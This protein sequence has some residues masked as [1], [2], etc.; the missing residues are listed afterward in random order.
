[1]E[2]SARDDQM[3]EVRSESASGHLP[4]NSVVVRG[5]TMKRRDL[6]PSAVRYADQNDGV[7]GLTVWSW[8]GMSPGEIALRVKANHPAGRNPVAHGQLRWSTVGEVR[9]PDTDG[10]AFNL[11]RT[12]RQ[13]GHYTLTFPS[14]PTESDWNRLDG[15][16]R[17]PEP[18]PAAD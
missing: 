7:Y 13:D 6:L 18:N 5:G 12:T 14:R 8:P 3:P 1:M 10:R 11:I 9:R 4:D 16:F 2:G 17:M 15:M